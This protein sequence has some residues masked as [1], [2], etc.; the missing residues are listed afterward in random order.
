MEKE[1]LIAGLFQPEDG[2]GTARLFKEVYGDAYPEA[3]VHRPDELIRRSQAGDEIPIVVRLPDNRIVGYSSLFRPAPYK[4]VYE[5]GHSAVSS[6]FR[7]AGLMDM[8]FQYLKKVMP[9]MEDMEVFCGRAPCNDTAMQKAAAAA[10][11]MVE[12][13]LEIDSLA[14]L[15]SPGEK[16]ASDRTSALLMFMTLTPRPHTVY[17]PPLYAGRLKYV[18]EGLDD[19]RSFAESEE[20]L[21]QKEPTR[22]ETRTC[23]AGRV[24]TMTVHEA[25]GDFHRT[26]QSEEK[27]VNT[28][29]AEAIH[30]RLKLSWPWIGKVARMLKDEGYFF[31]GIL[32]QW[33]GEDGFFMQKK[34]RR[35]DWEGIHLSSARGEQ[36]LGLVRADWPG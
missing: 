13:G 31:G 25:G 26:F 20:D 3:A 6:E 4:G 29:G 14:S 36:I 9:E 17:I 34:S 23:A 35:P 30:V 27:T 18:Y 32:P 1:G 24:A 15:I 12:T 7:K 5:M 21:P 22:I 33:F 16:G 28:E 2:E 11:P 10:L 19:K 8:I